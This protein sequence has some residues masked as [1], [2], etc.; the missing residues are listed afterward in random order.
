MA[1]LSPFAEVVKDKALSLSY[2]RRYPG[3]DW[4]IA[5]PEGRIDAESC[6][7]AHDGGWADHRMVAYY[8]HGQDNPVKAAT[9]AVAGLVLSA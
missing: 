8:S 7:S 5:S 2:A 1:E 6:L 4:S 3:L 9:H